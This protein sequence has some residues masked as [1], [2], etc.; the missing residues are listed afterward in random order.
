MAEQ[1]DLEPNVSGLASPPTST[2]FEKEAQ[3]NRRPTRRAARL[4]LASTRWASLLS[5]RRGTT[6]T[7]TCTFCG[8]NGS[9]RRGCHY[10]AKAHH[11]ARSFVRRGI[12]G[13]RGR[14]GERVAGYTA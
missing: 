9:H 7:W 13:A 11:K 2:T 14:S 5:D 1:R 3:M 8:V 4:A 6:T 12:L 10:V